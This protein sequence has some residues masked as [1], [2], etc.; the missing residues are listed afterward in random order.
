M[1][2]LGIR[3]GRP[4]SAPEVRTLVSFAFSRGMMS[5]QYSSNI[6]WLLYLICVL[7]A[8]PISGAAMLIVLN[9]RGDPESRALGRRCLLASGLSFVALCVCTGIANFAL[10]GLWSL[11]S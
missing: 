11:A 8:P 6:R 4:P 1:E 3:S 7:I 9:G 10:V 2:R 5:L